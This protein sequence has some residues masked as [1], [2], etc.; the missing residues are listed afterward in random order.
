MRKKREEGRGMG[1]GRRGKE[2]RGS[3]RF[4]FYIL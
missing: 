1:E 3:L 4:M 2:K